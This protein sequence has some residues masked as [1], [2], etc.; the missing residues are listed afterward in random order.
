IRHALF[1]QA[2]LTT[3]RLACRSSAVATPMATSLRRALPSSSCGRGR[4][5]TASAP[6]AW[7]QE[8][9]MRRRDSYRTRTR[10]LE[11]V[12]GQGGELADVVDGEVGGRIFRD[13]RKIE[14]IVPLPDEDSGETVAPALLHCRKD[15]QLVV[16]HDIAVRRELP[17]D[18]IER[19][20]LV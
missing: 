12:S 8:R 19:K 2:W 14:R 11:G 10:S 20:F 3:C 18:G 4:I 13:L 9:L 15:A 6:G 16:D 1:R 17:R 5:A 7:R